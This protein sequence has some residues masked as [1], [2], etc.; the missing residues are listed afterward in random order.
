MGAAPGYLEAC[1]H[2]ITALLPCS[3]VKLKQGNPDLTLPGT[4]EHSA[5]VSYLRCVHRSVDI[6]H[7]N[8]RLLHRRDFVTRISLGSCI[9]WRNR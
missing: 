8:E 9:C 4:F 2:T 6:I 7:L 1:D 3:T 5:R